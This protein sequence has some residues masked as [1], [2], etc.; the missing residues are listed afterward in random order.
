MASHICVT[1]DEQELPDVV[2]LRRFSV[3]PLQA[4]DAVGAVNVGVAV[5]W[6]V[7]L[8]PA[9]PMVGGCVSTIVTVCVLVAE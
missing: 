9:V 7:T 6:I 3:A 4:S 5:H 8:A 1:T 2:E